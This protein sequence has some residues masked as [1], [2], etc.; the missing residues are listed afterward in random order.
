MGDA[1]KISGAVEN[2]KIQPNEKL[3]QRKEKMN[4][5]KGQKEL[6]SSST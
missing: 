4:Y 5:Q 2:I 6:L 3:P 1:G